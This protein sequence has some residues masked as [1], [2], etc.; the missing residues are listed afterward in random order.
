M[1]I[2]SNSKYKLLKPFVFQNIKCVTFR[3][4]E[5]RMGARLKLDE[6][7]LKSIKVSIVRRNISEPNTS[8]PLVR[9]LE[10]PSQLVVHYRPGK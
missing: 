9:S 3:S 4:G 2:S 7:E 1:S 5:T 10:H 8:E 6:T